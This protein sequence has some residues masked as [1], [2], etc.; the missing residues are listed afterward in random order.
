MRQ[1]EMDPESELS[2][3]AK[4]PAAFQSVTYAASSD[5]GQ[6]SPSRSS[7]SHKIKLDPQFRSCKIKSEHTSQGEYANTAANRN[8]QG[9]TNTGAIHGGCYAYNRGEAE[10]TEYAN[11]VETRAA[12]ATSCRTRGIRD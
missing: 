10:T 5:S 11:L 1:I 6:A 4:V 7:R 2:Q 12:A 9:G 8:E 3:F